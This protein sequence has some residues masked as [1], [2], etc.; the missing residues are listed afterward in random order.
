MSIQVT[1][2]YDELSHT[3]TIAPEMFDVNSGTR[4]M[5]AE[6]GVTFENNDQVIAWVIAKDIPQGATDITVVG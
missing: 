4:Q 6:N 3:L 2:N 1:Y 5:L